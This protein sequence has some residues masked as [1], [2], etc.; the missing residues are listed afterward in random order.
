MIFNMNFIK[1]IIKNLIDIFLFI[2]SLPLFHVK[3]CFSYVKFNYLSKLNN[4][5]M[6]I[7]IYF[8]LFYL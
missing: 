6:Y 3:Y 7:Y 8:Q 5:N 4:I 2:F 1:I